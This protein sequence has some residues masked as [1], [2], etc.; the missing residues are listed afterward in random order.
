M[1]IEIAKV[2]AVGPGWNQVLGTDG[3]VYTIKGDY[4]W[5]S[6]N[7]GNIEYGPFA[8]SHGAI[9]SGAVPPGRQRGFA[10]FPTEAAGDAAR[11]ALLFESPNYRDLS[12]ADAISRYAPPN[13]NNTAGYIA[14]VAAAAGV[15]PDTLMSQLSEAQRQAFLDEQK[16]IEGYRPGSIYNG[17]GVKLPPLD[18]P[19]GSGTQVQRQKPSSGGSMVPPTPATMSSRV[20]QLRANNAQPPQPAT[21]SPQTRQRRQSMVPQ[22]QAPIPAT[23]SPA[24]AARRQSMIPQ[25]QAPVP[26][27]MSA[28][29]AARRNASS[30]R[31]PF[32]GNNGGSGGNAG[33]STRV[34][35]GGSGGGGKLY[36]AGGYVYQA[37]PG[38][39]YT[40]V[41]KVGQPISSYL[42][43]S[44]GRSSSG[45]G[46]GGGTQSFSSGGGHYYNSET[47][48]WER[49]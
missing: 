38:G 24:L 39:G 34:S 16:R 1:A 36:Q 10:I 17:E 27:T 5:R 44:S 33:G 26:A 2:L 29:L 42:S 13:E 48:S 15:T 3:N 18:I 37:N 8:I 40:K 23:M 43:G 11:S 32:S 30:V 20:A 35:S 6:N 12:I 28:A 21:M 22:M 31:V 46:G 49:E 45:G 7:P 4:N 25:V 19:S 9:G 47:G 14:A 41:G